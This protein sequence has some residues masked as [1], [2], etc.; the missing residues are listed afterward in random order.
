MNDIKPNSTKLKRKEQNSLIKTKY[1]TELMNLKLKAPKLEIKSTRASETQIIKIGNIKII[2]DK[3]F[4]SNDKLIDQNLDI[5]KTISRKELQDNNILPNEHDILSFQQESKPKENNRQNQK[6]TVTKKVIKILKEIEK[7]EN[8]IST[9]DEHEVKYIDNNNEKHYKD[10]NNYNQDPLLFQKAF[11]TDQIVKF[12]DIE[13]ISEDSNAPD[14][15]TFLKLLNDHLSSKSPTIMSSNHQNNPNFIRDYRR[16]S[17]NYSKIYQ[18]RIGLTNIKPLIWRVIQVPGN[19][20]FWDLHSA[21]QNAMG[22]SDT[23]LHMFRIT[24][25]KSRKKVEIGIPFDMNKPEKNLLPGWSMLIQDF[26][27]MKNKKASYEYDF[28]LSWKHNITLQKILQREQVEYPRCI[29]GKRACPP[30][31]CEDYG[32]FLSTLRE[33]DHLEH[34]ETIEWLENLGII[35]F[36]AEYF[37]PEKVYFEDSEEKLNLLQEIGNFI[38]I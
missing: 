38:K 34:E 35:G 28:E 30:E 25:P 21:I 27:H 31:N 8:D 9:N 17:Y 19:F 26:F 1:D 3:T 6:T 10:E 4:Y 11:D 16:P 33:R 24:N 13:N 18:F 23:H 29:R 7:H 20:T 22:W 12:N 14:F 32:N 2:Q 5:R 36:D 37:D 15:A